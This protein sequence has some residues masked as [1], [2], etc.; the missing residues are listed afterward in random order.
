[1]KKIY[2]VSGEASG[3]L[4]AS[5]LIKEIKKLQPNTVFRGMGGDKLAEQGMEIV[6]HI[7]DTHFMG[8]VEVLKNIRTILRIMKMIQNDI[9]E[10]KPDI[11]IL[12]DY[13]GFNLRLAKFIH[14][15]NIPIVYFISPQI[16]AW[17]KSRIHQIKKYIDLMLC[18]LPFEKDFY[19]KEGYTRVEYVGHPLMDEITDMIGKP[20]SLKEELHLNDKPIIAIL[21]GS[22]KQEIRLMLTE[23]LKVVHTFPDYQFIIAAVPHIP[24]DFYMKIIGEKKVQIVKGR[25][26][27]LLNIADAALV[28]SGT[29]TLETGLFGVPMVVCYKGNWISYQIAKRLVQVKYI[30]LVNL[31]LDKPAVKEL[32]QHECHADDMITEL[33]PIL[34]DKYYRD[35]IKNDLKEL[36]AKIGGKGASQKAAEIIV[37]NFWNT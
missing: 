27:E 12:V 6:Q 37:K 21:P 26:Y 11:V 31:I 10:W 28:T 22:R 23:M 35:R 30:S 34:H 25:T 7:K 17:K 16:W 18:I 33:N 19:L 4:H 32:I 20:N 1:M 24:I 29:A 14:S 9:Q 2:I 13:P 5:N 36:H 8:F 3:D 15:L